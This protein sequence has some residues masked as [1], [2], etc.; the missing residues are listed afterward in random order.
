MTD[1]N[2]AG[3]SSKSSPIRRV[4]A[5]NGSGGAYV[6]ISASQGSFGYVELTECPAVAT[7]AGGV[8]V[9]EGLTYQRADENYANTYDLPP[10]GI[11]QIGDAIQKN[12]AVGISSMTMPDGQA[13]PATPY[14]KVRSASANATN[15]QTSEYRQR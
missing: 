11:L 14:W 12:Q 13:R 6:L 4:I 8:F 3:I 10:G 9:G 5:I 2:T 15:V 1:V 7:Y